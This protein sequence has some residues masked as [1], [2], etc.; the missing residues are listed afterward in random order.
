MTKVHP[1]E[2]ATMTDLADYL[3]QQ[4]DWR[5]SKA[6]EYPD[7]T[8][9]EQSA[10][11]LRSLAEYVDS[12][13]ADARMPWIVPAVEAHLSE[14][15][16]L[17]AEAQREVSR[18][19]FGYDATALGQHEDF[20]ADLWIACMQDAYAFASTARED[21]SEQLH[22]CEI[23]AAVRGVH[24]SRRYWQLRSNCTEE[25]CEAEIIAHREQGVSEV[26]R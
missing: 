21:P 18:Y 23:D 9:N 22:S 7:D 19:G 13:E 2:E 3:R 10:R 25:E 12:G 4:A 6:E 17:G 16:T 1:T 15:F 26:Q 14:D 20:L 8:R 24:L 11:A 5:D